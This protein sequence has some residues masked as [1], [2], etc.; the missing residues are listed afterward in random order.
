MQKGILPFPLSH[1]PGLTSKSLTVKAQVW[2]LGENSIARAWGASGKKYPTGRGKSRNSKL[3]KPRAAW[4]S[5]RCLLLPSS[6]SFV[7][8]L[9]HVPGP[10]TSPL[11]LHY[12]HCIDFGQVPRDAQEGELCSTAVMCCCTC[13]E[14]TT[15]SN[16]SS[17]SISRPPRLGDRACPGGSTGWLRAALGH[18][19]Q[20]SVASHMFFPHLLT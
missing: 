15:Y 3:L 6:F 7:P 11:S 18:D 9:L 8:S 10:V 13:Q 1:L 16:I 14:W 5:M 2:P 17:R 12:I 4:H 20:K 19:S